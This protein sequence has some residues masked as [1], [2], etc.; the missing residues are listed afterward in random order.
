MEACFPNRPGACGRLVWLLRLCKSETRPCSCP[1]LVL[2]DL[3]RSQAC[4]TA[5]RGWRLPSA[6]R[7]HCSSLA[8]SPHAPIESCSIVHYTQVLLLYVAVYPTVSFAPSASPRTC[9]FRHTHTSVNSTSA[10]P[11]HLTHRNG[12]QSSPAVSAGR[13]HQIIPPRAAT[14]RLTEPLT[15]HPR[16]P[17]FTVTG[18]V[19]IRHRVPRIAS[20]RHRRRVRPHHALQALKGDCY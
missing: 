19:A 18:A 14:S 10:R 12:H 13:P 4:T 11:P 3:L 17:D 15:E 2:S 6:V 5:A 20:R 9:R 16:C 8:L 1:V 7:L